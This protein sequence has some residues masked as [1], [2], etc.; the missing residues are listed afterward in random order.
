MESK[1]TAW[2]KSPILGGLY[3]GGAAAQPTQEHPTYFSLKNHA[4]VAT[5][6]LGNAVPT[7]PSCQITPAQACT[8]AR[9][10]GL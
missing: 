7:I 10:D 8:G 5:S 3:R 9:H 1:I 6:C 4:L 2:L